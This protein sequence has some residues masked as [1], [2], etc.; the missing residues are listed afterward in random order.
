V[1]PRNENSYVSLPP[2][3]RINA[4][5]VWWQNPSGQLRHF[6]DSD[7]ESRNLDWYR[8]VDAFVGIDSEDL[9]LRMRFRQ[10]YREC[11]ADFP[12]APENPRWLHCRVQVTRW[13][14][15]R[16]VTFTSP[17]Q[18][19]IVDFMLALFGN[20]GYVEMHQDSSD[21]RSLGLARTT[22]L[23]LTAKGSQV[24]VDA[25]EPWQPLIA[26]CAINWAMWMQRETLFFHAAAV[27][28]D[29]A[30][31]LIAGSKGAGK[32]TLSTAL[33]ASGHDFLGDE[34]AAVQPR[35]MRLAPFRR[36]ISIRPGPRAPRVQQLLEGKS[37]P[38][39]RFPDGTTRIRALASELFP[40]TATFSFP[41]RSLFFLCGFEEYPRVEAFMPRA[42]D[43]SLLA[44][45][46]CTFWGTSP[47][48]PLMQVA[49][50]LS[51][52]NCY[53]LFPGAP[54]ETARL[55]ERTVRIG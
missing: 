33:A 2:H 35:T 38:T 50:L 21:W 17:E 27:A 34:I 4:P 20:R 15:A 30:G 43:L 39:E 16:L 19:D 28:I 8:I 12:P 18:V 13:A 1:N 14:P 22:E 25:R 54:E 5:S 9:P 7:C 10:L 45:L 37:Y 55:V 26:S 3:Q 32:S 53:R 24:L 40:E 52:V 44:P 31:V 6:D 11:L 36:S 46:P 29:G 41:L 51:S 23:L 42:T 48:R 47:A 49:K